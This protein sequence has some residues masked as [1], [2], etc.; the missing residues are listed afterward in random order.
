MYKVTLADPIELPPN[1][2]NNDKGKGKEEKKG[3]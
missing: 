1:K 3:G 2:S